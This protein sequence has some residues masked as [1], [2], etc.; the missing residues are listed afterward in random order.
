MRWGDVGRPGFGYIP[1]GGEIHAERRF[2]SVVLPSRVSVGWWYGTPRYQPFFE[3]T[4]LGAQAGSRSSSR[5]S[6]SSSSSV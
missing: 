1:F 4:I 2:G 5:A 3:A 6:V